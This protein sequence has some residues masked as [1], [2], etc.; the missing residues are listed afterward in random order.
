MSASV[1]VSLIIVS[2]DRPESLRRVITALRHQRDVSFELIVVTNADAGS[3]LAQGLAEGDVKHVAFD[4]PNISAARNKGIA[5]ASAD[6]IAFC[7]DDCIPEPRWLARLIEPFSDPE[8]GIAGGYVRGRNGI[9]F[10]WRQIETNLA[11]DD[12]T[13]EPPVEATT[14][15]DFDVAGFQKV[16]GTNCAFRKSAVVDQGGFDE[17]I[18]FY[19]DETDLCLRV[20]Q[21]GWKTAVVP[22]AEVQHGF[23]QSDRRSD[24]RAPKSLKQESISKGYFLSKHADQGLAEESAKLF[25]DAQHGRLIKFLNAGWIEPRDVTRLLNQVKGGL[26]KGAERQAEASNKLELNA[27]KAKPF[28]CHPELEETLFFGYR[29][30]QKQLF[31]KAKDAVQQGNT[32]TVFCFSR[33]SLFHQRSFNEGGFWLQTGGIFGKSVRKDTLFSKF[34]LLSRTG[35]EKSLLSQQRRFSSQQRV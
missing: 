11:G 23:E 15:F 29:A 25:I 14:I 18:R 27:V 2:R 34:T 7:D 33:T 10:Q 21:A 8:V 17:A 28:K 3:Y 22:L 24:S 6:L 5:V 30:D 13:V 1:A 12:Q 31:R 9:S 26:A 35:R 32:V 19:L 20:G 16:Q 4:Q